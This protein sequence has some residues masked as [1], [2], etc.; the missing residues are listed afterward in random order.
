MIRM[1]LEAIYESIFEEQGV[2]FGFRPGKSCSGAI[3]LIREKAQNTEW[4]IEGDIKD[5]YDN[6][7]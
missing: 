6:I 2:N 7:K 3:S 5:A 1:I 4:C